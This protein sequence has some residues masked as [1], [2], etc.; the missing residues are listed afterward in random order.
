VKAVDP[1]TVQINLPKTASPGA[2]LAVLT[3]NIASIVDSKEVQAHETNGDSGT[4]WLLDH[5][6]GSGAYVIDHWTKDVEVLLT[7]NP[8]FNGPKPALTSVLIRHVPESANQLTELQ[9]GDADIALNL[10]AEQLA[11]LS[12]DATSVKGQDLRLFY[13]GMNAT[14]NVEDESDVREAL[15][16]VLE[17]AGH[18]VQTAGDGVSGLE[19]I[20]SRRPHVAILD[21]GL[22]GISGYE[23]ARRIREEGMNIYLIALTGYGSEEDKQRALSAGFDA[24]L[25]KPAD[26]DELGSLIAAAH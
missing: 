25:A 10:T 18:R 24:H 11:T 23:I 17:A 7:A 22:P 4:A 3:N 5:S 8:N 2:F 6:A 19:K 9:Q 14:V 13:V 15:R 12:G 26:M 20:R 16:M 21:I 1:E